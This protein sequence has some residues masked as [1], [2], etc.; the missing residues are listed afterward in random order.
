ME[1]TSSRESLLHILHP[2]RYSQ[3]ERALRVQSAIKL[4]DN[5]NQNYNLNAQFY[6]NWML[7]SPTHAEP[8][9]EEPIRITQPEDMSS[10]EY[11][12]LLGENNFRDIPNLRV[13]FKNVSPEW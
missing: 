5:E 2:F 9:S 1:S 7:C 12:N 4:D 11:A 8:L 6:H 3:E 10:H 13:F